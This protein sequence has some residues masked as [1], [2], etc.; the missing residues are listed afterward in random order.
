MSSAANAAGLLSEPLTRSQIS[1]APS[2]P[3]LQRGL[4]DRALIEERQHDVER[5]AD[6]VAVFDLI[7]DDLELGQ[8]DAG[9]GQLR[10][11]GDGVLLLLERRDCR[12]HEVIEVL[13]A[14]AVLAYRRPR[15]FDVV[16]ADV[17]NDVVDS[18][19]VLPQLYVLTD[20]RE[21]PWYGRRRTSGLG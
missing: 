14:A 13:M 7:E 9:P 5:L 19:E 15:L 12:D 20:R 4:T 3:A 10:E 8:R 6:V 21:R 17:D 1:L 2:Q 11:G 16:G 18:L